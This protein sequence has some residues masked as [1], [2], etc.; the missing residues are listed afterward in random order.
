MLTW[1]KKLFS[2]FLTVSLSL[3]ANGSNQECNIVFV[4]LGSS[5]PEH[6]SWAIK[7]AR[8]FNNC[9]I[10]LVANQLSLSKSE[11]ILNSLNIEA[12]AC[13]NLHHTSRHCVFLKTSKLDKSFRGGFWFFASERFFYLDDLIQRY[14]LRNVIHLESDVMLYSSVSEILPI[15]DKYYKGLAVTFDNDNRCIP[16]FV[17]IRNPKTIAQLT[18]CMSC[19]NKTNDMEAF[20]VFRNQIGPEIVTTLPIAH[21]EY[22]LKNVLISD[23]PEDYCYLVDEFQ[24]LFDPAHFGQFLGGMDPRNGDDSKS[25]VNPHSVINASSFTYT[26]EKDS[27]GR[28]IPFCEYDGKKLKIN[29]LH[30]HSKRLSDFYSLKPEIV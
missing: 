18:K 21:E 26:W 30:I 29:N 10:F 23:K 12:V 11:H 13:E 22:I 25:Y 2:I 3:I 16:G 24:S 6:L 5:L 9:R 1:S 15:L 27:K 7:Q 28:W 17:Y 4:H 20:K 8:L 14:K 19:L